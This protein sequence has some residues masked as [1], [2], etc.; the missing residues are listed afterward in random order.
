LVFVA[1]DLIFVDG[2]D[3]R[4][5]PIEERRA[6]LRRLIGVSSRTRRDRGCSSAKR[7]LPC[8]ARRAE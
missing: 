5:L 4:S 3:L 1:F 7:L 8:R 6:E 2:K